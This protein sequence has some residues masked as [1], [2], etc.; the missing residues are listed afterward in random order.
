M[1]Q[2]MR[3][4]VVALAM[5]AIPVAGQAHGPNR[6]RFFHEASGF[7]VQTRSNGREM[8]LKGRNAETGQRFNLHLSGSGRVTG[9]FAGREVDYR[10][11]RAAARRGVFRD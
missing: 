3:G 8:C 5:F 7:E 2:R 1:I 6:D 10:T 9:V 11:D 4:A